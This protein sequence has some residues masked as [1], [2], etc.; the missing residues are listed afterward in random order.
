M[1]IDTTATILQLSS[2]LAASAGV[3]APSQVAGTD[4]GTP[5]TVATT[6]AAPNQKPLSF[7]QM[8][9]QVQQAAAEA[10]QS[11]APAAA[12]EPVAAPAPPA[13]DA[14]TDPT[15]ISSALMALLSQSNQPAA[16]NAAATP[17]SPVVLTT[18]AKPADAVGTAAAQ[19]GGAV[20]TVAVGC[21]EAIVTGSV[22]ESP[23]AQ[24][25]DG[26]MQPIAIKSTPIQ[27]AG[28]PPATASTTTAAVVATGSKPDVDPSVLPAVP[29]VTQADQP[30]AAAETAQVKAPETATAPINSSPIVDAKAV[31][32][33]AAD[34]RVQPADVSTPVQATRESAP[35]VTPDKISGTAARHTRNE[36][37]TAI[38]SAA[39]EGHVDFSNLTNLI[40]D[41]VVEASSDAIEPV[42][43]VSDHAKSK[44]TSDTT[45]IDQGMSGESANGV[46]DAV[47][48]VDPASQ[49]AA[50][51]AHSLAHHLESMV[52]QRLDQP[53]STDKSSVVLRL[54]PPELGRVNVHLSVTNDVVSIRM[55]TTDDAARQVIERQLN[56]LQ[57]SLTDKGIAFGD[58]QVQTGG[59]GQQSSDRGFR[60]QWADNSG[61]SAFSGRR[62]SAAVSTPQIRNGILAQ[63]DYVA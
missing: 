32:S 34:V 53:E 12:D 61:Y 7:Q 26:K 50:I 17:A 40:S 20:P 15:S 38:S 16:V 48:A 3:A 19:A 51:D 31:D 44:E 58:F 36:V 39:K 63:L 30:P 10:A 37:L 45:A 43:E 18:E 13:K 41:A 5:A 33:K 2:V 59:A 28:D 25:S 55:V 9:A 24:P 60:K 52:M 27:P 35:E 62:G 22:P 42:K 54:D 4:L 8:L 57:Q 46:T 29:A 11:S 6:P 56:Q 23:A 49:G 1:K 47:T 21:P 14:E